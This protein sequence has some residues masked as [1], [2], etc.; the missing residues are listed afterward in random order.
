LTDS[1]RSVLAGDDPI[2][3]N[4]SKSQPQRVKLLGI[5]FDALTPYE[6]IGTLVAESRAGSGGVV[7]TPNLDC[8]RL[9]RTSP[10]MREIADRAALVVADGMPLIWASQ[11]QGTPLPARVA[12][13][14]LIFQ[15]SEALG[16]AGSSLMLVGG[17]YGT[18]EKAARRLVDLYPRLTVLGTHFPPI[19]FDRRPDGVAHVV[20]A[21]QALRPDFVYIGLPF[22][23]AASLAEEIVA[24]LPTTWCLGLGVSFS[25]VA[26]EI[27]RCPPVLQQLGLEWLFRLKEEPSRLARRYLLAD[28]PIA[29]RLFWS[30]LRT[31]LAHA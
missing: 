25:F 11:L 13:S 3:G 20:S 31:R 26:Q 30:A 12:G 10:A 29:M 2:P 22:D 21:V 27:R 7:L 9:M 4:R 14:D 28:P 5:A 8:I 15:L 24:A 16:E 1:V 17:N 6:L 18:A 19:G 23:K